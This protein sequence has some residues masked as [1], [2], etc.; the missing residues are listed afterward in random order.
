MPSALPDPTTPFGR[1]VRDRLH[2]ERVIWLTTVG[3]DGTPQP[4][5]VWFVWTGGDEILTYNLPA[6][7][8]M[9]HIEQ[10]PTV[11]LHFN[12]DRAANQVIVARGV[13]ELADDEPPADRAPEFLA[14]YRTAMTAVSGSPVAFAARYSAPVRVRITRV[15]GY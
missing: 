8:R 14:K 3:R 4:N 7:H 5:P 10:R 15:R 2:D 6:A 13:A 1:R 12:S 11:A 9:A